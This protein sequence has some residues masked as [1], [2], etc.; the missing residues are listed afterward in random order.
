MVL[1][2]GTVGCGGS[3]GGSREG[4][5]AS[6]LSPSPID[7]GGAAT[8]DGKGSSPKPSGGGSS[9]FALVVVTDNNA[10]GQPDWGDVVTFN[11]STTATTQPHV[12]LTCRQNGTVVLGAT[13]GFYADYPWPWTQIMTLSS[14]SWQG[15]AADCTAV[16][17]YFAG[18]KNAVLS[19]L[20]FAAGQ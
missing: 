10:N 7:D 6:I 2:A 5:P 3:G 20:T 14:P 17:Y 12:D 19:T 16:L 18:R 9:A 13:T 4:S 8:T 1:A 11:V 15:G